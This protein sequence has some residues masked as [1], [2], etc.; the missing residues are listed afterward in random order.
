[1][2]RTLGIILL[3][4][5]GFGRAN[6]EEIKGHPFAWGDMFGMVRLS[7]PQP[8]P[9]GK[10]ILVTQTEYSVETNKSN[11]DLTLI[12]ADGTN[13]RRLTFDPAADQNGRWSLDGSFIY[14]LSSRSGSS[15]I[16]RLALSGGEPEKITDVPVDI[17]GFEFSPDGKKVLFWAGVFPDCKDLACTAKRLKEKDENKVKAMTFDTPFIRHWNEWN[18]GRRNHLF[19]MGLE[20]KR[21]LDLMP[22]MDQDAPTKPYGGSEE[23]SWS[24][25]GKL[26]AFTSKPSKGE[27]WNTNADVYLAPSDGSVAPRSLTEDNHAMDQAPVFSHD[28]QMLAYLAMDRPGYESDRFHIMLW[29]AKTG[30]KRSLAKDWDRSVD[31]MVWS[32]DGKTIYAVALESGRGKI[33]AVNVASGKV[34]PLVEDG[35]N[36][37][38]RLSSDGKLLFL[39]ERMTYPKEVFSAD[40]AT[41]QVKAVSRINAERLS[42][43][44]MSK[45]E[46]FWF[47]NDGRKLHGWVLK[48]VDFREGQKYPVAFLI[49]GGPQGSWE[50]N[51]HYRWNPQFYAGAGYVAVQIDF[52]GSQGYGQAF[53]DAIHGN[54]GPGP[55]SDLMAGLKEV[56]KT[57][58]Y[59]DSERMCAL[60]GSFGGY[61]TNWIEGQEHPFKCLVT[62]D[63][64][65]DTT[66]SYFNTE[67]IWFPEWDMTGPPWEKAEVYERN[68]PMRNVSK[69][70]TPMLVIHGGKDFRVVETEGFSTFNALSRRG[71]TAKLLYFP[72]EGHWVLKPLNSKLWHQTVLD[73][74]DRWTNT[75][76]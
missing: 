69:W 26:V 27:A 3:V 44:R 21:P 23:F 60:G 16:H 68:S 38:L 49:H 8:S 55:Y 45:P 65:F 64:D 15:Q 63:G 41:G 5:C 32:K 53:T 74:I 56:L 71:I 42:N 19:V 28:G 7:D 75:K 18:D 31:E 73:W 29:D 72:D 20:D 24:P 1:M 67:E 50:D 66:S 76:R 43:V 9:D 46:E 30:S 58:P 2:K 33:W 34:K 62:H 10:W 39:Q 14:F 35:V 40:P 47:T 61:M 57:H 12:S 13:V 25:D 52:R 36:S 4:L 54:W 37:S 6:A 59:A 17:E 22:G 11:A 48:P 51:F 70:K